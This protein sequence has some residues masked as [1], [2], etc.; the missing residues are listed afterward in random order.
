MMH[1]MARAQVRFQGSFE[2]WIGGC[3]DHLRQSFGDLSFGGVE[4]LQFIDVE[5]SEIV[6]ISGEELHVAP[7]C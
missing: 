1:Q 2:L 5:F 3:L 7:H 6:E 4:M